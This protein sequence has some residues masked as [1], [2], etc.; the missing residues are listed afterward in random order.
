MLIAQSAN[1]LASRPLRMTMHAIG[2]RKHGLGLGREHDHRHALG[3]ERLDDV[4][5][6]LLGADV[7]AA[8]RLDQHQRLRRAGQPF[9]ER[10]LLLIAARERAQS[11]LDIVGPDPEPARMHDGVGALGGRA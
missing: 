11:R 10:D 7:H 4:H 1:S 2:E 5:D 3:G 8:R 9:G 6:V